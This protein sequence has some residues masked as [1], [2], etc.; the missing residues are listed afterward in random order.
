[1]DRWEGIAGEGISRMTIMIWDEDKAYLELE[2]YTIE[3]GPVNI[4]ILPVYAG[5]WRIQE[6]LKDEEE[7][8]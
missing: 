4:P 7:I 8:A 1:M 5:G 2:G 6:L 3:A